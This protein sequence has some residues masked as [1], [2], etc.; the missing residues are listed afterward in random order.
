[1]SNSVKPVVEWHENTPVETKFSLFQG[2]IVWLD[3]GWLITIGHFFDN[4]F[5]HF[6]TNNKVVQDKFRWAILEFPD[7]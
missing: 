6:G 5:Y 3:L 7:V 1:M 4:E 2:D